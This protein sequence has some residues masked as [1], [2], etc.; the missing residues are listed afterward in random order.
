[1]SR[2]SR[3]LFQEL[4]PQD[5]EVSVLPKKKSRNADLHRRRNELILTR[6]YYYSNL[7]KIERRS[8]TWV[9]S[10]MEEETFLCEATIFNIINNDKAIVRKLRDANIST[11]ELR[12]KYPWLVWRE[13]S[14][15][16]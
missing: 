10:K 15:E 7:A 1:M 11:E 14:T 6:F 4:F 8:Y 13:A 12:L 16:Q 9:Q 3:S 5:V 2:G